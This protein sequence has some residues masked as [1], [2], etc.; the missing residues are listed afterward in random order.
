MTMSQHQSAV[1]LPK[2]IRFE[3]VIA[4]LAANDFVFAVAANKQ[5]L[6]HNTPGRLVLIATKANAN[7][8]VVA[9]FLK[10]H[11]GKIVI[12]Y[13][14]CGRRICWQVSQLNSHQRTFLVPATKFAMFDRVQSAVQQDPLGRVAVTVQICE[15]TV[16]HRHM[17]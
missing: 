5:I 8:F 13:Q 14:V 7:C 10:L 4:G 17:L 9:A 6:P 3:A 11:V 12:L 15:C 16:P 1:A 2:R